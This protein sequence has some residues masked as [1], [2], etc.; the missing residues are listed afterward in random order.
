MCPRNPSQLSSG[1]MFRRLAAPLCSTVVS[2]LG[3]VRLPPRRNPAEGFIRVYVETD[4]ERRQLAG[5]IVDLLHAAGR[6]AGVIVHV[7]G[8]EE[9]ARAQRLKS[10]LIYCDS[11]GLENQ[12]AQALVSLFPDTIGVCARGYGEGYTYLWVS[13]NYMRF[14]SSGVVHFRPLE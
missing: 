5:E 8:L 14:D 4:V 1:W 11:V 10:V 12:V 9:P 6:P 7:A 13:N 2:A 3:D